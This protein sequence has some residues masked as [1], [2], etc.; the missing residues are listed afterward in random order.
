[1]ADKP[2]TGGA[3]WTKD[4]QQEE[5]HSSIL[6]RIQEKEGG[7]S[8]VVRDPGVRAARTRDG[9]GSPEAVQQKAEGEFPARGKR[10]APIRQAEVP[11]RRL[12]GR[13]VKETEE[14]QDLRLTCSEEE[15]QP[16][17]E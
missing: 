8:K 16:V 2:S 1:M 11:R 17:R 4:E 9:G 13:E 7:R 12:A 6:K 15:I 10:D 3:V 14:L 5:G